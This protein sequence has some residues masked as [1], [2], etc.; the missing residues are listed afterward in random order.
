M[1]RVPQAGVVGMSSNVNNKHLF[2]ELLRDAFGNGTFVK[3]TLSKVAL[4]PRWK[5][6]AL[7]SF[8]DTRGQALISFDFSDGVQT[9]RKNLSPEEALTSLAALIPEQFKAANVRLTN[10]EL[11]FELTDRGTFRLKR[12]ASE[13][14]TLAPAT[15]NREK[16]YLV[17]SSAPFLKALGITT[18]EGEVRRDMYDKFRQIN[19][20]IEIIENLVDLPKDGV[21]ADEFA[22]IDFGSGKH[23]LTFALQ[24]YLS[25]KCE[26]LAITAVEQRPNLV[27][28][29]RHV[30]TSLGVNNIDFIEG[31]IAESPLTSPTLVVALHA[32]DT[33]TDDALARAITH[34]AR[35]I[36]VAPCCH[37][38]V[39]KNIQG[40]ESLL[41][42]MLRHG[43]L[44]ERFAESLTD[45]LRVLALEAAGY[46]AKLFEFISPEH[47]AK[48]TMITA[49]LRG[50]QN[51]ASLAAIQRLMDEFG[52]R[53][54]YLDAQIELAGS[55]A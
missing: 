25:T 38:Y 2:F 8:T 13:Q 24:H 1:A 16:S 54:F 10:E 52:L 9:E 20:F 30:A 19:K 42:P 34:K 5:R 3:A 31:T 45:T 35:Y 14:V 44:E 50:K 21:S 7:G 40:S 26:K 48:N 29:G 37:K 36:C 53:D 32:C 15:H 47:T 41:A 17:P 22:V 28:L 33:A 12:R 55:S 49:A 4:S 51:S 39:R 11:L 27:S 43:I 6:V 18:S 46:E 23:Y